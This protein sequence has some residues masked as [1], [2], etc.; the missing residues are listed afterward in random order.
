[1]KAFRSPLSTRERS[2]GL[3]G[4]APVL[5]RTCR[6]WLPQLGYP[7]TLVTL[8]AVA[9]RLDGGFLMLSCVS[10]SVAGAS[11]N[12]G[13]PRPLSAHALSGR[14][15]GGGRLE[16]G[17]QR[18]GFEATWGEGSREVRVDGTWPG[19]TNARRGEPGRPPIRRV[20]IRLWLGVKSLSDRADQIDQPTDTAREPA[21]R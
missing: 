4:Q 1:M 15:Q 3:V 7:S 21:N 19:L 9:D 10:K 13:A 11:E 14:R 18:C 2:G 6:R 12:D 17:R 8:L 20:R 16:L 5:A